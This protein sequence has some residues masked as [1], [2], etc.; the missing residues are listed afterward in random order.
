M[1]NFVDAAEHCAAE[2]YSPAHFSLKAEVEQLQRRAKLKGRK[3]GD[4][5]MGPG[6]IE[7]RL[8]KYLFTVD[9]KETARFSSHI[10]LYSA[11]FRNKPKTIGAAFS[12]CRR[13]PLIE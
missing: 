8:E 3:N 1:K 12:L 6:V 10:A 13:D 7:N 9:C 5:E 4:L 11:S 2:L